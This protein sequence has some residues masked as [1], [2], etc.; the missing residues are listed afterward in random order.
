MKKVALISSHCETPEKL[1][2][3]N[4]NIKLLK[5]LNVDTFVISSIKIDVDC[6]FL[7]ITKENPIL[8]WPERAMVAWKTLTYD[9]KIL[10]LVTL[11]ADYGWASLYQ[12]KKIMEFATTYD[13][14]IFYFLIYDLK[15]DEKIIEDINSNDYNIIYPRKDLIDGKVYPSSFHFS[16][17]NKEKLKLI[18]SLIDKSVYLSV[19]AGVAEDFVNQCATAIGM[20]R[21]EHFVIDLIHIT[22]GRKLFNHST[23]KK[24]DMFIAKNEESNFKLFFYNVGCEL[25]VNINEEIHDVNKNQLI[26]TNISFENLNTL[27]VEANNELFDYMGVYNQISRNLIHFI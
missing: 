27:K 8:E 23:S 20:K 11:V 6:D 17:F 26:E 15:I 24:Y 4:H 10:K 25:K 9:D 14:D 16:I 1:D 19:K 2:V 7:F 21:S 18:S 13:Y 3:L 12:I 5:S 22:D